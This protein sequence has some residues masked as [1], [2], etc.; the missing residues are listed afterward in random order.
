MKEFEDK[1]NVELMKSNFNEENVLYLAFEVLLDP[2]IHSS[3][4]QRI[5]K[6]LAS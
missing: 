2:G 6:I 1:L 4:A 5:I 3:W